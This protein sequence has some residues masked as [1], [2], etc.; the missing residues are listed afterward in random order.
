MTQATR[1]TLNWQ[2]ALHPLRWHPALHQAPRL[3]LGPSG[4]CGPPSSVS[5]G[6]RSATPPRCPHPLLQQ[7][8]QR[9][10]IRDSHGWPPRSWSE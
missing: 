10:G 1:T 2:A 3:S 7:T 6:P 5:S 8:V 4:S 9:V